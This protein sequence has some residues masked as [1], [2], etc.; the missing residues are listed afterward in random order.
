MKVFVT[1]G[2]GFLGKAIVTQL[3]ERGDDVRSMARS[4]YPDLE[5]MGAET[6]QG[7]LSNAKAVKEAAA[8][9]DAVIHIAARIGMW[10]PYE[11]FHRTNV[12]GT[13]NVL[14]ACFENG[15]RRMVY[16][17]SPSVIFD[18]G[19]LEGA[20]ESV[21]YPREYLAHYPKT[22]AEAE[23][24]VLAADGPK[25]ATT[26]LRPH[27][28]W[29][30]GDNHLVPRIITRARAGKLK[31]VGHGRYLVDTT[32]IDDGA[33]AH[34]LALDALAP[35]SKNAGKPYFISQGEPVELKDLINRILKK[36][37]LPPCNK[38]VPAKIAYA[39]GWAMEKTYTALGKTDEPLMTRFLAKELSTSHYFDISAAERDFGY[40]PTVTIDAGLEHLGQWLGEGGA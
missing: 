31:F 26:S 5:A 7:D 6:V 23:Q 2:G 29:G 10:G 17:S 35:G 13:S 38:H 32:Y 33:R 22:K 36:A 21:P 34:I 1:G 24:M 37:G 8:G 18:K 16:T 30:P 4:A 9:C 11:E 15:I 28:I 25:L 3:L 27:L 19:D 39:V 40:T 20:D 14:H 12:I